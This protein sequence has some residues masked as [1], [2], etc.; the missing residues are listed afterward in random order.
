[1][2]V[3]SLTWTQKFVAY[4][5]LLLQNAVAWYGSD[6]VVAELVDTLGSGSCV[7][8]DVGVRVSPLTSKDSTNVH[9]YTKTLQILTPHCSH[10]FL[11]FLKVWVNFNNLWFKKD[12]Q[13]EVLTGCHYTNCLF[14]DHLV[15]HFLPDTLS[16]IKLHSPQLVVENRNVNIITSSIVIF[17]I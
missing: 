3:S 14:L 8:M 10:Q 17:F 9:F 15:Y 13:W 7:L 4:F 11:L 2:A 12:R 16:K 1:M 6:A 5:A